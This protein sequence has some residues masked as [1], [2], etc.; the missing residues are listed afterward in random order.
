MFL[1][2]ALKRS[3]QHW[4]TFPAQL[5]AILLAVR[6]FQA[7]IERELRVVLSVGV[8]FFEEQARLDVVV[9]LVFRGVLFDRPG[10][11]VVKNLA[12]RRAG[13]YPH[14]LDGKNLQRPVARE[15]DVAETGCDVHE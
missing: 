3:L 9:V 11:L 2:V 6:A 10:D 8:E 1:A 14:R 4:Q 5:P 12:D 15:T 7:E 13:V